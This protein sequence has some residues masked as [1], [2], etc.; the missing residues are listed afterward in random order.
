MSRELGERVIICLLE[1]I[2]TP[3]IDE[4]GNEIP[5]PSVDECWSE[6]YK[7]K[8]EKEERLFFEVYKK[9]LEKEERLFFEEDAPRLTKVYRNLCKKYGCKPRL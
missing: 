3:D 8:L 2:L 4:E 7:K 9:A 1:E 6:V 5:I